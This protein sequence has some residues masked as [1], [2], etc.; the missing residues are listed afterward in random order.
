VAAE[1]LILLFSCRYL[2]RREVIKGVSFL[3]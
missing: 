2:L 1:R 3:A